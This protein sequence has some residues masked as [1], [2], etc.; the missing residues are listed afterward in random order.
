[1]TRLRESI[2]IHNVQVSITPK[3]VHEI[4]EALLSVYESQ[5]VP[6]TRIFMRVDEYLV[7]ISNYAILNLLNF[8]KQ[9]ATSPQDDKEQHEMLHAELLKASEQYA[10][11]GLGFSLLLH[12]QCPIA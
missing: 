11:L 3:L 6:Y 5:L 1:M 7:A 12:P 8:V 4:T 2:G 9:I 10:T